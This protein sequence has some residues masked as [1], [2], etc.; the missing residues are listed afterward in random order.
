MEPSMDGNSLIQDITIA[1]ATAKAMANGNGSTSRCAC[2]QKPVL[3]KSPRLKWTRG[4]AASTIGLVR[5]S[6]STHLIKR[7]KYPDWL[8]GEAESNVTSKISTNC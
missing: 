4:V 5:P 2:F 3:K 1:T 8:H 6:Q 7:R